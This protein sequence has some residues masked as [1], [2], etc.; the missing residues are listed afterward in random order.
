M[1]LALVVASLLPLVP[2]T[3]DVASE[4]RLLWLVNEERVQRGLPPLAVRE[5]VGGIAEFHS[6]DM[7][8]TGVLEHNDEYF[9]DG[10][11]ERL[12]AQAL[13]ENVAYG[14]T[15]EQVHEMLMASDGHR[16]NLLDPRFTV[17]G[18]GIV[19]GSDRLWVTQDFVQPR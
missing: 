4:Q 10:T 17:V 15:V 16:H 5:D 19:E 3:A 12:D 8:Q 7:E 2:A 11:R 1:A 13:G 18:I 14:P 6:A 9:T